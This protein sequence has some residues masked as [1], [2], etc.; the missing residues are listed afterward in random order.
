M[1]TPSVLATDIN[2]RHPEC[3]VCDR[4]VCAFD[5][6]GLVPPECFECDVDL[7]REVHDEHGPVG[8]AHDGCHEK[9]TMDAMAHDIEQ[10]LNVR[11]PLGM[12]PWA[13]ERARNLA[14][15]MYH[16]YVNPKEKQ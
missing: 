12:E 4:A 13:A 16:E 6:S 9:Y 3:L 10:A 5:D 1:S 15:I 11:L 14:V 2:G 8:Y 7:G